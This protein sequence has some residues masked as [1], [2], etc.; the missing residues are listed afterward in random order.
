MQ[1]EGK[2]A[3]VTGG[4]GGIGKA[5]VETFAQEGARV[6]IADR[7]LAGARALSAALIAA[8]STAEAIEVDVADSAGVTRMAAQVFETFGRI[9]ILVNNAG[10]RFLNPLLEQTE[11]EWR[12]TLD[13]NLTGPFL[14]CKAVIP[15]M[16]RGGKGK[17]VNV[18]SVAGQFGRPLRSA[19]CASKGG[20]I[21]FT[22]A[23]ALDMKG[24]NIYINALAPAL[25][26]TP[27]NA[28]FAGDAELAPVW[29]KE[30]IVGRWGK[31]SE[32]AQ[33]ALFL[34]SDASDFVN[35]SV[36]T[37]DGGWT[38]AMVRHGE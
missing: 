19:Y 5:I 33:A 10:I 36:L 24:K 23:A 8:G 18:S 28:V 31:P 1:L 29:G 13:V 38:A 7:N 22:R 14:C 35:G 21:A 32:V 16:L 27:L 17:I 9:D 15:Y 26:D 12:R 3:I 37:V 20:E 6:A 25:V 2:V 11:D 30:T 4:G 34:A